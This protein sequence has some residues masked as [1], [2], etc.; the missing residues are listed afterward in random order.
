MDQHQQKIELMYKYAE[1]IKTVYD[2]HVIGSIPSK[3]IDNAIKK[4]AKGLDRNT[5]IG[6][7]D[8]TISGNGKSGYIFTDTKVYYLQVLDKPKK[9]WYDDIL[10]VET[11]IGMKKNSRDS[12][13]FHMND[14][15]TIEWRD[16][17]LNKEPLKDFFVD[18]IKMVNDSQLNNSPDV[19]FYERKS[20]GSLAGGISI[21][22]YKQVNRA[23]DEERFHA[24]QGHGFAAERANSLYDKLKLHDVKMLGD[25]NAKNGPDRLVDGVMI[26]SKYCKTGEQC[27]I[28]C[29]D[30]EGKFRYWNDG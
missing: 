24:R 20:E 16:I 3:K 8:T 18:M 27:I 26:Q 6:L 15:T 7:Y 4:Y 5:I 19:S 1:K 9:L 28:E 2:F 13:V 17:S 11:T 29:F 23:F 22:T 12:I 14:G 21:G 10:S 25:D 30:K